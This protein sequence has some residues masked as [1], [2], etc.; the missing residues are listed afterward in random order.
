MTNV[1]AAKMQAKAVAEL[2]EQHKCH[3]ELLHEINAKLDTILARLDTPSPTGEVIED[4]PKHE[5][6]GEA[7]PEG[8]FEKPAEGGPLKNRVHGK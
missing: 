7:K 1:H 3:D 4:A 8:L 6:K 5:S 2:A